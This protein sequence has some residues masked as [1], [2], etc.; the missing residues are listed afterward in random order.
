MAPKVFGIND[1]SNY[2]M[3]A[4]LPT[5]GLE[6]VDAIHLR[7]KMDLKDQGGHFDLLLLNRITKSDVW[8]IPDDLDNGSIFKQHRKKFIQSV[9]Q[10]ILLLMNTCRTQ[11]T[12]LKEAWMMLV[13]PRLK[14]HFIVTLI[15]IQIQLLWMSL[16]ELHPLLA[17][18][19]L[20]NL[21]MM[22][23]IFRLKIL[24]NQ[25]RLPLCVVGLPIQS[26]L[27]KPL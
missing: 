7:Y 19:Q 18:I 10:L 3:Q 16:Q 15:F 27:L 14:Y 8:N 13:C 6:E 26:Y 4:R 23:R 17:I 20:Q 21:V 25:I 11:M 5:V 22:I 9:S 2:V 12:L 24:I 1:N